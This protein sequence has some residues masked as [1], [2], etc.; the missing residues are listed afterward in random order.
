M[1]PNADLEARLRR[2]RLFLCDV[3]GVLTD[4]TVLM[5][6][7]VETKVFE[8]R[9]GFGGRL[10]QNA[11][12]TMS[13]RPAAAAAPCARRWNSSSRPRVSGRP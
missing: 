1:V 6:S 7:G 8:I 3:D 10:M 4:G 9:D 13:A 11:G 2:V 5:G 12:T